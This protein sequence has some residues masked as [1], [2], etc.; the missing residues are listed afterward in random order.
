LQAQ[1]TKRLV[2]QLTRE[3]ALELV[4]VLGGARAHELTIEFGISVHGPRL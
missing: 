2:A 3:V 4:T 1:R